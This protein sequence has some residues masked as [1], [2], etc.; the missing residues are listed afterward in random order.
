MLEI[1][2]ELISMN[3]KLLDILDNSKHKHKFPPRERVSEI[4][5]HFNARGTFPGS[6]A[7]TAMTDA[8]IESASAVL[9]DFTE[10]VLRNLPT[11]G[12]VSENEISDV[13]CEAFNDVTKE[14]RGCALSEFSGNSFW[15][16][17]L[18]VCDEKFPRLLEHL[19]RKV[20][21]K[22][23]NIGELMNPIQITA[24]QIG[25]LVLGSVNQSELTATVTEIVKQGGTEAELGRAVQGL[26][27]VIGRMDDNKKVEQAELFDLVKGLLQQIKLPKQERSRSTIKVIWD[28]VVEVSRVSA[29]VAQLVQ[30]VLP[31]IPG[32]LTP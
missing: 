16:W 19:H 3:Q 10:M 27:E 6:T 8:Y 20:R 31:M 32:L 18:P 26:I 4:K 14:A 23:L 11:V 15:N 5:S 24:N 7:A 28:R 30:R 17:I 9:E 13:V 29:E 22:D 12:L 2:I 1:V 25:N 21:L